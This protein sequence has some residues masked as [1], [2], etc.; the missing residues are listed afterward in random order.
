[1]IC[2]FNFGYYGFPVECDPTN[3][4][5]RAILIPILAIFGT[6]ANILTIKIFNKPKMRS[7]VHTI[8]MGKNECAQ[9]INSY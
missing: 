7:P 1:M 6:T 4:V 2:F 3:F 9:K 5:I 8:L